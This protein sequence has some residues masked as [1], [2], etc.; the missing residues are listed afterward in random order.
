MVMITSASTMPGS[1]TASKGSPTSSATSAR[2]GSISGCRF[3]P[4]TF[5]KL[6]RLRRRAQLELRLVA[7]ADH[8]EDL[9]VLPRQMP[10]RHRRPPPS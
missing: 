5:S 7:R 6:M 3:Q 9:G 4:M 1:S 8:A 10:D 2:P